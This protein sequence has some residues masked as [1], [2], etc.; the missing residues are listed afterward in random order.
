MQNNGKSLPK[1][2]HDPRIRTTKF[3]FGKNCTFREIGFDKIFLAAVKM[4]NRNFLHIH[5]SDILG[6]MQ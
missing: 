4:Q 2:F 3:H 6:H 1:M 5:V